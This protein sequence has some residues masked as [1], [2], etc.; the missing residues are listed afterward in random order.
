[1][2]AVP[3]FVVQSITVLTAIRAE[4]ILHNL[5]VVEVGGQGGGRGGLN[6]RSWLIGV[7]EVAVLHVNAYRGATQR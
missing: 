4:I 1:M 3:F 5:A 2:R 7:A 6:V